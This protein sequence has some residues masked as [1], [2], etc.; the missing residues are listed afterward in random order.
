MPIEFQSLH[1]CSLH[2]PRSATGEVNDSVQPT[3]TPRQPAVGEL[4]ALAPWASAWHLYM[5]DA[6][7]DPTRRSSSDPE[8][9][10]LQR[11]VPLRVTWSDRR[12]MATFTSPGERRRCGG[13][14][15]PAEVGRECVPT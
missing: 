11:T 14:G 7:C 12:G 5:A 4:I 3:L 1:R 6:N 9:S 15:R 13:V 8:C 10:A 2:P